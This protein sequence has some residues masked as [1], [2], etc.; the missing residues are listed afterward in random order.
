MRLD[1]A[2]RV[3]VERDLRFVARRDL[4][5]F[6]LVEHREDLVFGVDEGHDLVERHAGHEI[7][8]SQHH[9]D[10]RA[11]S[12]RDHRRLFQVP[13]GVLELGARRVDLRLSDPHL[14]LRR[15]DLRLG[16]RHDSRGP[17]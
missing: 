13:A 2:A 14:R 8:R 17:P 4:V 6:V 7:A 12:R 15:R 10:H 3:G 1:D 9:V 11:V 16:A 5:Q